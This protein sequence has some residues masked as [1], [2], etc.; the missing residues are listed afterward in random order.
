[1][2]DVLT[3]GLG[4]LIDRIKDLT[5]R[6]EGVWVSLDLDAIDWVYAPGVGIPNQGGLSYREIGLITEYIGKHCNVVGMDIVEYNPNADIDYKTAE[7][8]I[9]LIAKLLGVNYSWYTNYMS[10]Q[11]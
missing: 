4:Q 1:M 2:Y 5:T 8:S 7:L 6:T 10:R 9:D 3:L 11:K